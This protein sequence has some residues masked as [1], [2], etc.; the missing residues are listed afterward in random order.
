MLG[1]GEP[2]Q[3]AVNDDAVET[4]LD[5]RQQVAEQL[6]EQFHCQH[7]ATRDRSKE[8]QTGTGQTYGRR[9]EFSPCR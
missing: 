1:P 2:R 7:H 6:G 9:Q 8:D 4:V 3:I 5:K